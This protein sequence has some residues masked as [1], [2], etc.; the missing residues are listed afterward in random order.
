MSF[1][2]SHACT[3]R[4]KRGDYHYG[5]WIEETWVVR[6]AFDESVHRAWLDKIASSR[7]VKYKNESRPSGKGKFLGI[8]YTKYVT[9]RVIDHYVGSV[10]MIDDRTIEVHITDESAQRLATET[11]ARISTV[12]MD[13]IEAD[14]ETH[15]Q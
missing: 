12:L 4:R 14:L 15:Q 9:A 6:V 11:M 13:Y 7:P 10:V 3:N 2:M 8:T 5:S 1:T